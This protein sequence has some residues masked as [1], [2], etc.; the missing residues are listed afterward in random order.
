MY[1]KR[2]LLACFLVLFILLVPI[3][4]SQTL[5]YKYNW[6]KN[7]FEATGILFI[8]T[9]PRAVDILLNNELLD[10]KT[11]FQKSK[12]SPGE[13]NLKI[14]KDNYLSW[15]KNLNIYEHSTTFVEDVVLFKRALPTPLQKI[16]IQE[17]TSS[18]SDYSYILGTTNNE[19]KLLQLDSN[20]SEILELKKWSVDKKINI[21]S[22]SDNN[23]KLI[24]KQGG[25]YKL[26]FI[27]NTDIDIALSGLSQAF[28]QNIVWHKSTDNIIYSL[29]NTVLYEINISTMPVVI[30]KSIPNVIDFF[31][32]EDKVYFLEAV[33]DANQVTLF[34]ANKNFTNLEPIILLPKTNNIEYITSDGMISIIDVTNSFL[35]LLDTNENNIIAKV[36]PNVKSANWYD[37]NF[38]KVLFW[39][40]NEISVYY[41]YRNETQ[42]ITR[43]S[44]P[45]KKVW[46]HPNG[47][48]IFYQQG[49]KIN[50]VEFDSRDKK[51]NYEIVSLDSDQLFIINNK[52]DQILYYSSSDNTI[53]TQAIQ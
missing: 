36:Y 10:D 8:K 20:N 50:I 48:Y 16:D 25:I 23:T 28:W 5:G 37:K 34:Q 52:G 7:K 41:K 51:N 39:N 27:N 2:L 13:Y 38:D 30:T 29:H 1:Q 44:D 12:L 18:N 33:D 3:L 49:N 35:Y 19:Q 46:W 21:V 15:E 32:H 6:H 17:T 42:L 31:T 43:V 45:I 26:L 22:V 24:Y 9:Y 11:P 4:L 40:D 47:T 53:Y 14:Q